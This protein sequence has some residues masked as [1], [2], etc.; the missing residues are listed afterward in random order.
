MCHVSGARCRSQTQRHPAT[1]HA[2]TITPPRTPIMGHIRDVIDPATTSPWT[3][4]GF[5]IGSHL[6]HGWPPRNPARE[7]ILTS[8]KNTML[9]DLGYIYRTGGTQ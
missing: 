4:P 5:M 9:N 1:K 6:F 7:L 2:E 8:G 3:R